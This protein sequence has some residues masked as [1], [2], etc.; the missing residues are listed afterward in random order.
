MTVVFP[1]VFAPVSIPSASVPSDRPT[2]KYPHLDLSYLYP[3]LSGAQHGFACVLKL[4]KVLPKDEKDSGFRQKQTP[5][6]LEYLE[7]GV[8][9]ALDDPRNQKINLYLT[10][11][12][13]FSRPNRRQTS[14]LSLTTCFLDCDPKDEHGKRVFLDPKEF[15]G[16][17][18]LLCERLEIP[19]PGEVISSG[20]G[21]Y[22]IWSLERP[23]PA[24]ALPRWKAVQKHLCEY[25]E[26]LGA[27]PQ[28]LDASRVLRIPG[29]INQNNGKRVY[30]VRTG[31]V[32]SF[33]HLA[34]SVLPKTRPELQSER[35]ERE[36][37]ALAKQTDLANQTAEKVAVKNT[38]GL[39]RFNSEH[40]AWARLEDLRTLVRLRYG[41]HVPEGKRDLYV[42][43]ATV[44]LS[45]VMPPA[46]LHHEI[47]NIVQ[48]FCPDW[49]I[50]EARRFMST[51]LKRAKAAW[52]GEK[53]LYNGQKCDPRYTYSN[54]RLIALLEIK[55]EEMNSLITIISGEEARKR[56]RERH[57]I[58]EVYKYAKA[59]K[60][61]ED[62]KRLKA[63]GFN[64]SQIAKQLE[65]TRR[66]VIKILKSA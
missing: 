8:Q 63:E 41:G 2:P 7:Q 33:E 52:A 43:L 53:V 14:L 18:E 51:I 54:V 47:T 45:F 40:L 37:K 28:A 57:R 50:N 42:F 36:Q 4:W 59:K 29:S 16:R 23:V 48:E 66:W 44:F 11:A 21:Y 12:G 60:N 46:I 24:R 32:V 25:F 1:A 39:L 55:P 19:A 65:M 10:T 30:E 20:R 22:L 5:F 15:L 56:D 6:R 17:V 64:N 9:R 34:E 26:R 61:E 58:E 3:D 49:K 31:N 13:I 27:D 35:A 62:V 38:T